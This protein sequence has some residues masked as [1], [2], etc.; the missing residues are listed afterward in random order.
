MDEATKG[1]FIHLF[2]NFA[3][4]S[5]IVD[6]FIHKLMDVLA[7]VPGVVLYCNLQ[8]IVYF[9]FSFWLFCYHCTYHSFLLPSNRQYIS[10]NDCL[11]YKRKDYQSFFELYCVP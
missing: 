5:I 4:T 10:S 1:I 8:L 3:I 6:L 2:D 7:C 11:E 9:H